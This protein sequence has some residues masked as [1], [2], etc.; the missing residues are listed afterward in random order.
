EISRRRRRDRVSRA[1]FP[2]NLLAGGRFGGRRHGSLSPIPAIASLQRSADARTLLPAVTTAHFRA[3]SL[4][5][6][7]VLFHARQRGP[8]AAAEIRRLTK[9]RAAASCLLDLALCLADLFLLAADRGIVAPRLP[10]R[11]PACG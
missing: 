11:S 3:R 8:D 5:F 4:Q 2:C 6:G 1:T 9:Y 10:R 7:E